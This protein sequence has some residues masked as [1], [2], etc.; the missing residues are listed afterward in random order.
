[1]LLIGSKVFKK[2]RNGHRRRAIMR[3]LQVSVQHASNYTLQVL[4]VRYNRDAVLYT[5]R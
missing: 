4:Y 5:K 2:V 1:M 3:R